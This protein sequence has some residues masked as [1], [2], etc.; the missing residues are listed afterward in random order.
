[1]RFVVQEYKQD[2][3]SLSLPGIFIELTETGDIPTLFREGCIRLSIPNETG[4][5]IQT[6]CVYLKGRGIVPEKL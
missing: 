2:K 1:M 5:P 3:D 6:I 4:K